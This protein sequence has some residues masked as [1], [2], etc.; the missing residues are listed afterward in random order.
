M[1]RFSKLEFG[2]E[3]AGQTEPV[4]HGLPTDEGQCLAAARSAFESANFEQG[5]RFYA[6]VL[7]HNPNNASAWAGQVRMLIE[8]GE[9]REAKLWA[10]KALE[11]F[12]HD[13][14]L[15][16]AKAVAL[17]RSGDLAGALA[18]SDAALEERGDFPYL[19]VAR[20]D[21]LLSHGE[22]RADF[23]L[24]KALLLAPQDWFTFW[25]V[26]RVRVY[27]RQFALAVQVVQRALAQRTDH[28]LLWL[29][30]GRC[31]QALA[32]TVPAEH[33]FR[34]ALQLN[35]DCQLAADALDALER[36]NWAAR[37]FGW[38]RQLF[39]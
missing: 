39:H 10:D 2:A 22:R 34:Q 38:G 19:W 15:L 3:S 30:L 23:C 35:P 11:R 24:D 6:K 12:P 16:A 17:G 1:S 33:S 14:E 29:E 20:G 28:F 7:E 36:Q 37:L 32:L 13:A 5:L 18:F 21:V 26:G 25:L 31:Q 4:Y 8:L 9:Q 27:H